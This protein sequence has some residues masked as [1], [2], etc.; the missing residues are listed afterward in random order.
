[1]R[2]Q[3]NNI[4]MYADMHYEYGFCNGNSRAILW[5]VGPDSVVGIATRFGLD[6]LGIESWWRKDLPH[7]SRPIISPNKPPPK[8]VPDFPG[9]TPVGTWC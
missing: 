2:S 3:L 9:R 5:N 6:G 4:R 1:M 8:W 7:P